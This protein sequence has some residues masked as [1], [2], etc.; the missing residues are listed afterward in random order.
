MII[1]IMERYPVIIDGRNLVD[2][3]KSETS[4]SFRRLLISLLKGER[5][6][7]KDVNIEECEKIARELLMILFLI[8]FLH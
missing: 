1:Q 7:N 4:G 8:E 5:S 6:D 2:D 3:I